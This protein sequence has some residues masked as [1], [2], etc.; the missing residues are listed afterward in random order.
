MRFRVV[1]TA[2][3]AAAAIGLLALPADAA[4]KKKRV[5]IV[6]GRGHTVFTSRN[7]DG[8]TRTRVI[9]QKRSYLDPGTEVMP[10]DRN[11]RDYAI[12]P[13]H[14]ASGVLDNTTFGGNQSALPGAFDLP[15]KNNPFLRF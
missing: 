14:K 4:P 11:D 1:A 7:E 6:N 12:L 15:S 13:N 9:I 3:A 2:F 10:G 8:R 5:V